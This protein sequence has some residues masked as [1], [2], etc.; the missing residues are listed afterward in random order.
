MNVI[1]FNV[2]LW[3]YFIS[4]LHYL[5]YLAWRKEKVYKIGTIF[6]KSG[7]LLHTISMIS[8]TIESGRPPLGNLHESI[9]VFAWII[10]LLEIIMEYRYNIKV[11]GS[12]VLPIALLMIISAAALP[13][14]IVEL[15]PYLKTT[16][17]WIHVTLV[18]VGFGAFV[19]NFSS[20]I[21]YLI[22]EKQL[23]SKKPGAFYYRL[24][25]LDILDNLSFKSLTFGLPF[26]TLGLVLGSIWAE[27]AWGSY[28]SWDPKQIFSLFT[29]IFYALM[30][31]ARIILDWRGRKAAYL[32][33]AGFITMIMTLSASLLW[34][35]MHIHL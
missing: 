6:L 17:V 3:I 27:Y 7:F 20:G 18:L 34:P 13:K 11:L 2:T 32:A 31:F 33:I 25:S 26:W 19:L 16:W 8:R 21:M 4:T 12:F 14:E 23:K 29:W 35:G 9:S 30:L 1:F 10:I 24:P 15:T 28:W 5:I 22:Q